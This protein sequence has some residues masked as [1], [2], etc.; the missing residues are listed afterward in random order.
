MAQSKGA[1]LDAFAT[2]LDRLAAD[3]ISGQKRCQ[4][5]AERACAGFCERAQSLFAEVHLGTLWRNT[6]WNLFEVLGRQRKEDDHS[7]AIAWLMDPGA[8]HGLKNTF[9]KAFFES[10]FG[11]A[12]PPGTL[13]CRVTVKKRIGE[14]GEVDIEVAGPQWRLI[15]ENKID[16]GEDQGQTEKYASHYK[17][18]Y[19]LKKNLF[20]VFLSRSGQRPQSRD[21][22]PMSYRDLRRVIE[23]LRPAPEV[24]PFVRQFVQHIYDDLES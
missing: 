3:W 19:T 4:V 22:T 9:L 15:V 6:H 1:R 2:S 8:A 24:E 11:K 13:E 10:A 17:S 5:A 7:R 18:Y 12:P 16:C 21:F 23:T 14:S 20:L